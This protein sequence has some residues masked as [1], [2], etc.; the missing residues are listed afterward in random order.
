VIRTGPPAPRN[1]RVG[2]A[3]PP[4]LIVPPALLGV[5]FLTLPTLG[6]LIR[7]PWSGLGRIYSHAD[8]TDGVDVGAALRLSIETSL[9][10]TLVSLIVGI[11]LAWVLA[12]V[13][14]PGMALV[15]AVVTMPLVLPPVVG[16][17]ALFLAFGRNG[18]VG[19]YLWDWFGVQLPFSHYGV[20]IAQTFVAMPFLV[21]TMEGAFRSTDHG[22]ED[23]AATLGASRTRI[24]THVTVPL[25]VPSLVAGTVLC[26]ARALGEFG[27][28][29]LFGGN[30]AGRTQTG[31]TAVLTAFTNNL[32]D[33]VALSL[34]LMLVAVVILAALRDKWLRP[35]A[36]A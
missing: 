8:V 14:L 22:L 4:W 3:R 19:R 30:V 31:P 20:V 24:F 32:G 27:A 1:A 16:G 13:R 11:P 12:R 10:A 35:I 36:N 25:A 18:Y 9:E 33:A 26:W 23:A 7:A 15:R 17:V 6:L 2:A 5:L 29:V 34:P 21:V 28:T